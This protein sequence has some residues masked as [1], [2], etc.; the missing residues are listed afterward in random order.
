[1]EK[2][3]YAVNDFSIKYPDKFDE[4]T[5]RVDAFEAKFKDQLTPVFQNGVEQIRQNVRNFKIA[6]REENLRGLEEDVNDRI[7]RH[8]YGDAVRKVQQKRGIF[9]ADPAAT[10]K[11]NAAYKRV[12]DEG[13]KYFDQ[14]K[15]EAEALI[16]DGKKKI[17]RA[18]C[19]ERV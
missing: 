18:S 13:S 7:K 2:A 8:E 16:K 10:E 9:S 14:Q 1:M 12:L 3:F 15:A 19:R 4:I 6:R 17:G 11:V 5:K